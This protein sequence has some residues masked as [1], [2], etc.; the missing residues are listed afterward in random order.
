MF[1]RWAHNCSEDKDLRSTM[2]E[3]P[4]PSDLL[5]RNKDLRDT[6]RRRSGPEDLR[7]ARLNWDQDLRDQMGSR[8]STD[9][10]FVAF[11]SQQVLHFDLEVKY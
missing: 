9:R 8:R 7:Y 6:M 1:R 2:R 10:N 4:G 3:R 11:S 5:N